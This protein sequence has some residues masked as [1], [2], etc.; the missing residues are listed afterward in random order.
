MDEDIRA[1]WRAVL[2]SAAT[3]AGAASV[4]CPLPSFE[5]AENCLYVEFPALGVTVRGERG[6]VEEFSVA[7]SSRDVDRR[8]GRI[9]EIGAWLQINADIRGE[10]RQEALIRLSIITFLMAAQANMRLERFEAILSEIANDFY[11]SLEA[12]HR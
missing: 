7:A 9:R 4:E 3:A 11:D 8:R 12:G 10:N 5:A 1:R 2:E 6:S